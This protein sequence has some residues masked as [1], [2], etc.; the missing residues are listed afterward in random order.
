MNAATLCYSSLNQTTIDQT[1]L[2]LAPFEDALAPALN[3]AVE[4]IEHIGDVPKYL[5]I[6]L[7]DGTNSLSVYWPRE[8]EPQVTS[9]G[10]LPQGT[11]GQLVTLEFDDVEA[12]FRG[13][14]FNP[15]VA[16][17]GV[18]ADPAQAWGPQLLSEAVPSPPS[19]LSIIKDDGSELHDEWY[20][21]ATVASRVHACFGSAPDL[22]PASCRE[23]NEIVRAE[24]F[25]TH[26]EDGL[27]RDWHGRVFLNPPYRRRKGYPLPLS[28]WIPK[29]IDEYRSGRVEEMI[30][31][32][33]ANTDTGPTQQLLQAAGVFCFVA[34]RLEFVDGRTGRGKEQ[35]CR[36]NLIAYFGDR[37][38][39]FV[40]EF[41][42]L[43]I[44]VRR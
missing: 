35:T 8:G 24:E 25:F 42:A 15:D 17:F 27:N 14:Q 6:D 7:D 9:T 16:V 11:D 43:G 13:L 10:E 18:A 44:I 26:V 12:T 40:S 28:L 21:P 2:D 23:A 36:H 33:H 3:S 22:D 34:G 29:A 19:H 31:L 1:G 39:R 20:T 30:I 5:S 32:T 38:D 41:E 4:V 37:S